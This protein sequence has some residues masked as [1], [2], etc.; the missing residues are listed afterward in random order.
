MRDIESKTCVRFVPRTTQADYI[1]IINSSGCWSY[2]GRIRGAQDLSL[3]KNGCVYKRTV[4]HELIHA[5][6][7][8]H[9][10]THTARDD[11]VTVNFENISPSYAS[12]FV[13]RN[14][15]YWGNFGTPYDL[16]SVMHYRRKAFS[17]N[18]LDTIV[19]RDIS[20][21]DKIGRL[22]DLSAGDIERIKNM[23]QCYI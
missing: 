16:L 12:N 6:G 19:P 11:Y 21:I 15:R 4:M 2:L 14:P 3:Q 5:L 8:H 7:Y 1:N 22:P 9:M 20:F 18:G 23:Y 17:I 10:Q 13:K